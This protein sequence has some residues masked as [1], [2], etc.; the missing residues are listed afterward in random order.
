[1]SGPAVG[2]W[3]FEP[4]GF[5]D[6]LTGVVPWLET[7]CDPVETEADGD[8]RF[9]VRD[10]SLL[11]LTNVDPASAGGFFLSEDEYLPAEDEDYSAFSRPPVQGLIL[12]AGCSGPENHLLL[13]HL[14][15]HLARWLGALVDFDGVLGYRSPLDG[16]DDEAALATA[17]ALVASLPGTVAEVFYDTGGGDR[18]FRHVGDVEFLTAWLRH[19]GFHL[20]K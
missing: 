9:W 12:C 5:E 10:A 2:L 8:L 6:V 15:L 20:I 3:L 1:M 11:G 7:F 17:R 4:R 19:P 13:G 14:A 16:P 18:W